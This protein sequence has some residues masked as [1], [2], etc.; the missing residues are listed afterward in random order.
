MDHHLADGKVIS[1]AEFRELERQ[2]AA[3]LLNSYATLHAR[4]DRLSC[5]DESGGITEYSLNVDPYT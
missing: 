2:H 4:R 5:L 3:P 1:A